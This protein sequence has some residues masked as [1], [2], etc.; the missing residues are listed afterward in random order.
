[1]DTWVDITFNSPVNNKSTEPLRAMSGKRFA[2]RTEQEIENLIRS[3]ESSS[4]KKATKQSVYNKVLIDSE[5]SGK[6]YVLWTLDC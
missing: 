2:G 4:T 6:Q 1:M 3:K 5:T